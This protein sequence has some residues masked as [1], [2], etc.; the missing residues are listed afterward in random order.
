MRSGGVMRGWGQGE[1]LTHL[2]EVEPGARG[3]SLLVHGPGIAGVRLGP[4]GTGR[5][6]WSSGSFPHL[7]VP[8][9]ASSLVSSGCSAVQG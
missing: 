5:W 9:P 7:P 2:P 8:P 1:L 6:W 3:W 4:P